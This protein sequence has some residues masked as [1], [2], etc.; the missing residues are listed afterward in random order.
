MPDLSDLNEGDLKYA[1]DFKN[2]YATGTRTVRGL[3]AI[4]LSLPPTPGNSIIRRPDNQN[5]SSI[6]Q[7]FKERGYDTRFLYGGYGYFDNMNAFFSTNGFEIVDRAQFTRDEITFS[8]AWGV[9]DGD[10]FNKT[11]ELADKSFANGK[12]FMSLIMTTSNH[13]PYTYPQVIDIKSGTGRDGAVKYTDYAIG[14][15][16]KKSRNKPWFKNTIFVILADH[17]ASVAGKTA[18]PL[19]DYQIPWMIYAPGIIQPKVVDEMVSQMDVAPTIAGVFNFSYNSK[20]L[21]QNLLKS[22]KKRALV[23]TY[24]MLG[25]YQDDMLAILSPQRKIEVF[26]V[27]PQSM[28][29]NLV[30]GPYDPKHQSIIDDVISYYQT[31][32]RLYKYKMLSFEPSEYLKSNPNMQ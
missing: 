19:E 20:F 32:S 31:S 9:C 13:R 7:L 4:S 30:K 28:A 24:Q 6:G 10:V 15:F 5:L 3:E 14:E 27:N 26:D 18:I 11:L 12:P 23:A 1:V 16:I 17:C 21:G 29:Q 25:L 22:H 2:V 8:N